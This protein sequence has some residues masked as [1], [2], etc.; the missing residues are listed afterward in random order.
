[1]YWLEVSKCDKRAIAF[2]QPHYSIATPNAAEL[3]PPGMK[4][5]LIGNDGKAVWGS[6]R[7]APW[8]K[9]THNIKMNQDEVMRCVQQFLIPL[10]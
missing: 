3:G 1:M 7:P 10:A 4:I 2:V 9:R 5:V 6:H 8:A